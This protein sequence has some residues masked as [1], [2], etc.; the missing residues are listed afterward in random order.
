MLAGIIAKIPNVMVEFLS[1]FTFS[2]WGTEGFDH[3]QREIVEPMPKIDPSQ[4]PEEAPK[5]VQQD[6]L[7]DAYKQLETN[8]HSSYN[9]NFGDL[10]GSLTLD[11]IVI[12]ILGL[13]CVVCIWW[14][15]KKKDTI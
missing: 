1:Y 13:I 11:F 8:F 15:L 14:S 2:R 6:S 10:S 9:S 12:S 4:N 3:I 7:I 5:I